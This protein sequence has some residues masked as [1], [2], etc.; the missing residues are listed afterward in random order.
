MSEVLGIPLIDADVAIET[1]IHVA[2][3]SILSCSN[4]GDIEGV[5]SAMLE[6]VDRIGQ[7]RAHVVE[8]M[9]RERGLRK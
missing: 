1:A 5:R 4:A 2:Y 9:E 3:A 6:M 7:R 8:R